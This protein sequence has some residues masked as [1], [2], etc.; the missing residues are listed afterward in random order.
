MQFCRLNLKSTWKK[1]TRAFCGPCPT[2]VD[3]SWLVK[4]MHVFALRLFMFS[5]RESSIFSKTILHKLSEKFSVEIFFFGG[6]ENSQ[7][8][9][10]L[11][12]KEHLWASLVAQTVK[13]VF[14]MWET[15]VWP[16]GWEDPL[17]KERAAHPSTLAWRI[18]WME[19]IFELIKEK[20]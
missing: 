7:E 6:D 14:T 9:V 5:R 10:Y 20:I 3:S 18:P 15:W 1:Q 17:E 4:L 19:E 12:N 16:L 8:I 2:P 11:E 13:C